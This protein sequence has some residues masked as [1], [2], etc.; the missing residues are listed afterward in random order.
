MSKLLE[1]C[2]LRCTVHTNQYINMLRRR[3]WGPDSHVHPSH[4]SNQSQAAIV[5]EKKNNK[6]KQTEKNKHLKLRSIGMRLAR[7]NAH[8]NLN[9]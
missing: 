9:M 7:H 2:Y 3:Q 5:N 8:V 1:A 4:C 6:R